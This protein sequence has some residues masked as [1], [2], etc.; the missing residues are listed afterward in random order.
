MC[1]ILFC[2]H[3]SLLIWKRPRIQRSSIWQ[4]MMRMSE[5]LSL[6]RVDGRPMRFP[7]SRQGHRDYS[8]YYVSDNSA[9]YLTIEHETLY[10]RETAAKALATVLPRQPEVF[11]EYLNKLIELFQEKVLPNL[12]CVDVGKTCPSEVRQIWYAHQSW[13]RVSKSCQSQSIHCPRLPT[14]RPCNSPRQDRVRLE[15]H[16][17]SG[18]TRRQRRR[19]TRKHAFS[20]SSIDRNT[21]KGQIG[22]NFQYSQLLS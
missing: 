2:K 13:T 17:Q 6:L 18:S 3:S 9:S 21:G 10:V 4:C 20:R 11:E 14:T 1:E 12:T 19:S 7:W 22:G 16:G 8:L 15:L 5:M